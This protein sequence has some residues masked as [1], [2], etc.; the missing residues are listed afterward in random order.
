MAKRAK[1]TVSADTWTPDSVDG[2]GNPIYPEGV[3][4]I[5]L[6]GGN[7]C[8]VVLPDNDSIK[9]NDYRQLDACLSAYNAEG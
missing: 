9:L 2:E 6:T 5:E 7:S 1:T 4:R 8:I 3:E